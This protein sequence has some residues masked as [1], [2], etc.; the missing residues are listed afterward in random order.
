MVRERLRKEIKEP[1]TFH[2]LNRRQPP[3]W[4]DRNHE[5]VG[6]LAWSVL[7]FLVIVGFVM[8]YGR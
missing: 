3:T 2:P 8:V 4:W 6:A 7:A 5:R 1:L